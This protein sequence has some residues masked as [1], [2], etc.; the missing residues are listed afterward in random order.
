MERK[1][2]VVQ[3]GTGKM[4][5]YTMRYVLEKGGEVVGAVDMEIVFK[6]NIAEMI[7]CLALPITVSAF[8]G[9]LGLFLN[10]LF[11][12]Y[13]WEN[14]TYIIKQSIPAV[15]TIFLSILIIGGSIWCLM[16][17]F[18]LHM[19]IASYILMVLLLILTIILALCLRR[20]RKNF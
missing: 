4:A 6:M 13:N 8:A 10:L 14:V 1:I 17:F 20:I 7:L 5:K 2:K 18:N 9:M 15:S 11:P 3:I 12:N 19:L 16:K